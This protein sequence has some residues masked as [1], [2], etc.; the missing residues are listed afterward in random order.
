[1]GGLQTRFMS[2]PQRIEAPRSTS[3]DRHTDRDVTELVDA[4]ID[5]VH[6][7]DAFDEDGDADATEMRDVV[8]GDIFHSTPRA[9]A[10]PTRFHV[11]E[12]G[13]IGFLGDYYDRDRVVYAGAHGR[14]WA[15]A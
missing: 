14:T 11:T 3:G 6:G 8:L 7:K 15:A 13:Y 2:S 5:Y 10:A 1:M 9:I 12:P 4:V